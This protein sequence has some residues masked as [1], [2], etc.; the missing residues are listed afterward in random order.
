MNNRPSLPDNSATLALTAKQKA[1][2]RI[3]IFGGLF[4]T[5]LITAFSN[6]LVLAVETIIGVLVIA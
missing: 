5:L 4:T 3:A 6:C 2:R 1:A